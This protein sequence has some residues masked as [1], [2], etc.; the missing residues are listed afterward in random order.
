M[1]IKGTIRP[2]RDK[3]II[4]NM[5]FGEQITASG[6]YIPT[7][8]GKEHGVKPRWGQVFAKGPDNDDPYS[9]GD[10]VLVEH[11]RWTRGSEYETTDGTIHTIRMIDNNAVLM[12][13]DIDPEST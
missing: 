2:L 5:N 1:K 10:W 11:G 4:H 6:I 12:W 7:D 9:V 3:V 8:N 13:S